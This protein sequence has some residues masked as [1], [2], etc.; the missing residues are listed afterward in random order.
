MFTSAR[1]RVLT[2]SRPLMLTLPSRALVIARSPPDRK[3]PMGTDVSGAWVGSHSL[4][5]SA[6]RAW[7]VYVSH[8]CNA[9]RAQYCSSE[10][11]HVVAAAP[12]RA[13]KLISS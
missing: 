12:M 1:A 11:R 10:L 13:R 9:N 3:M 8:S 2:T 4:Q 7:S 6:H 5:S